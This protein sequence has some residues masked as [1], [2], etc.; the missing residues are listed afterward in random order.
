[1]GWEYDIIRGMTQDAHSGRAGY[2]F[3]RTAGDLL[4]RALGYERLPGPANEFMR[5]GKRVALKCANIGVNRVGIYA[6]AMERLDFIIAAFRRDDSGFDLY[7]LTRDEFD[8]IAD[9]REKPREQRQATEGDIVRSGKF[10]RRIEI[11]LPK[12]V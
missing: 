3:G 11:R 4:I 10:L 7:E 2:Q 8:S 6:S 12:G 5:D 1:M 9:W